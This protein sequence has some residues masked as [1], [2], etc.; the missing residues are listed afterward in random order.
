MAV[1]AVDERDG[2]GIVGHD[3]LVGHLIIIT[4]VVV[5]IGRARGEHGRYQ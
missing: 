2:A 4:V 1:D 5:I 3:V